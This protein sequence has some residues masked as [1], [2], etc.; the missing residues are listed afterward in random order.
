MSILLYYKIVIPIET[1]SEGISKVTNGDLDVKIDIKNDDEFGELAGSFNK[2]IR[3]LKVSKE[4]IKHYGNTLEQSVEKRT[5]ELQESLE[6]LENSKLATL[7]ILEDVNEAKE[8]LSKTKEYLESLI[9][10]VVDPIITTDVKGKILSFSKGAEK[11]LGYNEEEVL[12]THVSRFYEGG[13]E[14]AKTI[15]EILRKDGKLQNYEIPL[16]TRDNKAH[17]SI[18]SAS[19]IQNGQG[20]ITGTIGIA[21][22]ISQRKEL[23]N[24]LKNT[25][26]FLE[27]IVDSS[28]DAITVVD[29]SGWIKYV[30]RGAEEMLGYMRENILGTHI[31]EYYLGGIEEAK[32]IM[33]I[34]QEE[35]RL[36]NYET[37]FQAE[38]GRII[39]VSLS[40]SLLKDGKGEVTGSLGIYSDITERKELEI[41]LK[42]TKDFLENVIESSIDAIVATNY[43]GITTFANK[44]AKDMLGYDIDE[45]NAHASEYYIGGI[46]EAQNIDNI[47]KEEGMIMGYET[48]LKVKGGRLIP[49][50]G[51]FSR[52]ENEDKEVIGTLGVFKDITEK[53]KLENEIIET[54]EYLENLLE[55]ANDIVCTIDLEGNFTYINQKIEEMGYK[56]DEL[57]SKSFFSIM[58]KEFSKEEFRESLLTP[59]KQSFEVEMKNRGGIIRNSLLST[60]PLY[61][62]QGDQTGLLVLARDITDR[63][64][65]EQELEKLSITDNLTGLYNQRHFYTELKREIDR[66][67][68]VSRPLSLIL[69]DLDNFKLCNDKYGHLEGDRIL[70]LVGS[71]VS[72]NVRENLD[73]GFR[74]GGDEFMVILPEANEK[75]AF[76]IAERIRK[77]FNENEVGDVTLSIGLVEFNPGYDLDTFI[78]IAD[79]TMY[80]SKKSGGNR[81][82]IYYE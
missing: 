25:K 14:D 38:D 75:E 35:E 66:S 59:I 57:I 61:N 41:K 10:S 71:V 78:K 67:L 65:L 32:K 28:I 4:Q 27:S 40:G 22:D 7:N 3:E 70:N 51:S 48:R 55:N 72:Q 6:S 49:I 45:V 54:K 74:Y 52:L 39:P 37:A 34:L 36:A 56:K 33:K 8:E 77:S 43:K 76:T 19:F 44:G 24:K 17:P 16:L 12:G 21:K 68:R 1:L 81:I 58:S 63:K 47:L 26:D 9:E 80:S 15:M 50:I 46:E 82:C 31:S 62:S 23:E 5:K 11:L 73:S 13:I 79:E 53:K 2:I 29:R 60:S 69:F 64:E 30:S 18:L 20:E 42:E